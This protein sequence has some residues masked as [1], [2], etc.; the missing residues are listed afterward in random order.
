M[1][2]RGQTNRRWD[3]VAW[4]VPRTDKNVKNALMIPTRDPVEGIEAL[5]QPFGAVMAQHRRDVRSFAMEM[6]VRTT[7]LLSLRGA[8]NA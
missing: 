2:K 4:S 6:H 7:R 1:A 3:N 8:I 5:T